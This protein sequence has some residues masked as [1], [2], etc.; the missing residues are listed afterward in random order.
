ME[1]NSVKRN[2]VLNSTPKF[3]LQKPLYWDSI[4]HYL[5]IY[6]WRLS[7]LLTDTTSLKSGTKKQD[8]WYMTHLSCYQQSKIMIFTHM[9]W[10]SL[11]NLYKG[12]FI[13][14]IPNIILLYIQIINLLLVFFMQNSMRMFLY[15]GLTNYTCSISAFNIF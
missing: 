1:T 11:F 2:N 7:T 5:L 4:L 14:S 9:S 3:V 8:S 12:I 15:A 10:L 13:F 6:T